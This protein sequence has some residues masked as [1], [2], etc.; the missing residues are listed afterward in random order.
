VSFFFILLT[1]S[2]LVSGLVIEKIGYMRSLFIAIIGTIL[3][4]LVGFGLG[5]NG[6]W[7]LPLSGLFV[8]VLFPTTLAVVMKIF[9]ADAQAI[10]GVLITVG[11][12]IN[13]TFQLVIGLTNQYA[14]PAWGYRSC[15]LYAVLAL[16][17]LI[18]LAKKVRGKVEGE[19]VNEL[20][21][22]EL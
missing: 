13:G 19:K 2:R 11:G 4:L 15:L 21:V 22:N 14:G 18:V 20:S 8:A 3:V 17:L 1:L 9:G 10:I 5:R 7:I 16:I 6:I 12:A